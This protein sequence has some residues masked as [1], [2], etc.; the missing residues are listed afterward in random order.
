MPHHVL[1][2]LVHVPS[3][4]LMIG[5]DLPLRPQQNDMVR[6]PSTIRNQHKRIGNDK[7]QESRRGAFDP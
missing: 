6:R 2:V 3:S 4:R 5:S 7:R 1:E